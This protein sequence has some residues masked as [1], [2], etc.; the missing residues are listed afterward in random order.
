M[1]LKVHLD[2]RLPNAHPVDR[3][4]ERRSFRDLRVQFLLVAEVICA[5]GR[6][7]GEERPS[8]SRT[9]TRAGGQVLSDC[10]KLLTN[11]TPF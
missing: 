8:S 4:P 6:S 9:W 3:H 10:I 2:Y 11:I 1:I 7:G 5:E